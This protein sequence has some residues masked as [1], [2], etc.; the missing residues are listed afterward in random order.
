VTVGSFK[1]GRALWGST[2]GGVGIQRTPVLSW[3]VGG[4]AF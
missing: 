2:V 3:K 1:R 4:L